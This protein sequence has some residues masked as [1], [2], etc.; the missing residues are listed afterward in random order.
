MY[1]EGGPLVYIILLFESY[2][3]G[4]QHGTMVPLCWDLVTLFHGSPVAS[5]PLCPSPPVCAAALL[6]QHLNNLGEGNKRLY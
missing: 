4:P 2:A 5:P 1:G 6:A 3:S